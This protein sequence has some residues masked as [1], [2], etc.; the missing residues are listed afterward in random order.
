M[1]PSN[2]TKCGIRLVEIPAVTGIRIRSACNLQHM[3]GNVEYFPEL[4]LGYYETCEL[5]HIFIC[6]IKTLIKQV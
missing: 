2:H 6:S 3:H 4:L 5:H 1:N